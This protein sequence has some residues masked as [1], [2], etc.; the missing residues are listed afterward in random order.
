MSRFSGGHDWYVT[1]ATYATS[2]VA[3]RVLLRCCRC[4]S[5]AIGL[6]QADDDRKY[7]GTKDRQ[8]DTGEWWDFKDLKIMGAATSCPSHETAKRGTR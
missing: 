4:N 7:A 2:P 3:S 6:I 8:F 5:L 1:E